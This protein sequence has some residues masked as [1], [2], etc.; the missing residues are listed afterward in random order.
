VLGLLALAL[1]VL[2]ILALLQFV[3]HNEEKGARGG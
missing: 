3:L 2:G 1:V